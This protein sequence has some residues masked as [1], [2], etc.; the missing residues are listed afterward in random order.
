[1]IVMEITQKISQENKIKTNEL[2]NVERILEIIMD[3]IETE[4]ITI[5]E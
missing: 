5:T 1:M 2:L 3:I 4:I